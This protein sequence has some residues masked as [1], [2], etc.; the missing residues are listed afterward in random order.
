[1]SLQFLG[2][3]WVKAVRFLVDILRI[4]LTYCEHP[5][6][7]GNVGTF[8]EENLDLT[9]YIN[10]VGL[11]YLTD[12]SIESEN[13]GKVMLPQM[14]ARFGEQLPVPRSRIQFLEDGEEFDIGS[15][16][17]LKIMFTSGHQT[18]GL[19]I[20]NEKNKGMFID[21]LVGN[22]F[23]DADFSLVLTPPR[24]DVI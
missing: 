6:H 23:I 24:S 5:D 13:R 8:I 4:F 19:I 15:E 10:P 1:M 22:Y 20:L 9:V 2:C 12:P 14:A 17:K 11:E 18:G 21:A 3:K 16:V 7:T